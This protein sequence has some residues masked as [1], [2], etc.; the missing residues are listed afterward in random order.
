[1]WLASAYSMDRPW[2]QV[3]DHWPV[4]VGGHTVCGWP[5][6]NG[7]VPSMPTTGQC[8]FNGH[9]LGISTTGQSMW[10]AHCVWLARMQWTSPKYANYWPVHIQWTGPRYTNHWPVHVGGHT[11][12][13]LASS[14]SMEGSNVCQLP[15]SP[16]G[17]AQCPKLASPCPTGPPHVYLYWPAPLEP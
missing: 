6:C 4:H 10:E 7:P 14:Y 8:I 11:V 3:Y 13:L 16:S 17:Q 2:S 15:A 12:M 1:M 9:V 5:V